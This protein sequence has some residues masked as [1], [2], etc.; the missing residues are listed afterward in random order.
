MRYKE[1]VA[2][3][4]REAERVPTLDQIWRYSDEFSPETNEQARLN[5]LQHIAELRAR[6]KEEFQQKRQ[7]RKT[8]AIQ[9]VSSLIH[10]DIKIF[11]HEYT[12][13]LYAYLI[14][15]P[16]VASEYVIDPN[17]VTEENIF[18]ELVR[19]LKTDGHLYPVGLAVYYAF[20]E[21]GSQLESQYSSQ[22]VDFL[23]YTKTVYN[24]GP[25]GKKRA[26]DALY[27]QLTTAVQ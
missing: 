15:H 3:P 11:I 16:K 10:F 4:I 14:D 19:K 20:L 7:S 23:H 13:Q 27:S 9:D 1:I 25:V 26:L 5:A 12:Q 6:N 17:T 24:L 18:N 8:F 2:R 22:L 21:P